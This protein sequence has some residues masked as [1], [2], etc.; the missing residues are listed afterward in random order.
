MSQP[1]SFR[2]RS[3]VI[4]KLEVIAKAEDRSKS[5]MVKHLIEAEYERKRK[6]IGDAQ[7]SLLEEQLK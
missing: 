3:D 5:N 2:L 4:E 6:E 1:Q 7:L